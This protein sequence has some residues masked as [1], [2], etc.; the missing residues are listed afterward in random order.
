MSPRNA[1]ILNDL[2]AFYLTHLTALDGPGR[3]AALDAI[4][5]A[6]ELSPLL[7][8]AR[9]N[10]TLALHA[11]FLAAPEAVSPSLTDGAVGARGLAGDPTAAW[12][13]ALA[14][15]EACP[16]PCAEANVLIS[17]F[18]REMRKLAEERLLPR[19]AEAVQRGQ[20]AAAARLL[21]LMTRIGQSVA[22]CCSDSMLVEATAL[23]RQ[24]EPRRLPSLARSVSQ[25]AAGLTT[26]QVNE[27]KRGEALLV[28]AARQL[29]RTVP[30]L[31][32]WAEYGRGL[33][34]YQSGHFGSAITILTALD[35]DL[36]GRYPSLRLRLLWLRGASLSHS[37]RN[38]DC[39]RD[40]HD[41]QVL[42]QHSG[43]LAERAGVALNLYES[44]WLL[45]Q[46]PAAWPWLYQGSR[47]AVQAGDPR[48]LIVAYATLCQAAQD[49]NLPHAALAFADR[50]VERSGPSLGQAGAA[51]ALL[52]RARARAALG[53]KAS[54]LQDLKA[55][56]GAAAALADPDSR[57]QWLADIWTER[58]HLLLKT[59]PVKAAT[60]LARATAV[61]QALHDAVRL[62]HFLTELAFA[63]TANHDSAA[64]AASLHKALLEVEAQRVHLDAGESRTAFLSQS[65]TVYDQWMSTS[66]EAHATPA[67]LFAIADEARARA[68][69]DTLHLPAADAGLTHR[70]DRARALVEF[71]VLPHQL[72]IWV[73]TKGRIRFHIESIAAADL[74]TWVQFLDSGPQDAREALR[75]LSSVLIDPI[76]PDIFGV[77]TLL[78]SP[79]KSLRRVP[80][81]ALA[82]PAG[83]PLVAD[84]EVVIV[85]SAAL[86]D[87]RGA[88]SGQALA[89][90]FVLGDP[91]LDAAIFSFLEPLPSARREATAIADLYRPNSVL[92]LGQDAT[93]A[94]F[95]RGFGRFAIVH[96]AAH[97]LAD[98][99]QPDL[100]LLPLARASTEDKVAL[101]AGD[102]RRLA[103]GRT[104]LVVLSS[105][106]AAGSQ[107]TEGSRGLVEAFLAT[108]VP[109]VVAALGSV[110]DASAEQF[111]ARFYRRLR[112]AE[113]PAAAL[114]NTQL[115][116]LHGRDPVLH[117]V[118]A[119][120]GFQ[121]FQ[122]ATTERRISR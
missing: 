20:D 95:S 71:A 101:S 55:A 72:L 9:V 32:W 38:G 109:A 61:A 99:Q 25:V 52:T 11:A 121:L 50:L 14:R 68:L 36:H 116:L 80:F 94:A 63:Q 117:E 6:L 110:D 115:E 86:A 49:S 105:C 74:E 119:W 66:I 107:D 104:R 84:H 93:A 37:G 73:M 33:C 62:I 47:L 40:Y 89:S 76:A 27:G 3:L 39:L 13:S 10:W 106:R 19:W 43:A 34:A 69:R 98:D 64:A 5:T 92:S 90:A 41:A 26:C 79:D 96:L 70:L 114:R 118:A 120:G 85:P 51:Y 28:P 30:A 24:A 122:V 8:E 44:L 18:P 31:A 15:F 12:P 53:R 97:V 81:A 46:R 21:D 1:C 67:A 111:F 60:E 103:A 87:P 91:R 54:A 7:P 35:R 82:G 4:E 22:A 17:S 65:R 102:I 48:R 42:A 29:A 100:S 88:T 113:G 112:S 83:Q 58:G 56:E 57:R 59:A 108:G 23:L 2:G 45:G 78:V 77:T 16:L 75:K